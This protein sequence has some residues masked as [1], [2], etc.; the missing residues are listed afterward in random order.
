MIVAE[1][2]PE[3]V[4][5]MPASHTGAF[6]KNVLQ[7]VELP[8]AKKTHKPAARRA[9]ATT[10]GAAKTT[11]AAKKAGAAKTTSSRTRRA[12]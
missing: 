12:G 5:A 9:A 3:Q 2:T 1:G 10:T 6:L 8:A 11:A 4:A 7:D